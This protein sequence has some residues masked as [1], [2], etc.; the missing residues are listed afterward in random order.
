MGNILL[1]GCCSDILTAWHFPT[2]SLNIPTQFPIRS[3]ILTR[4]TFPAFPDDI[5]PSSLLSS[6]FSLFFLFFFFYS[7]PP[8][9]LCYVCIFALALV[10][11]SHTPRWAEW[12][13]R[14]KTTIATQKPPDGIAH[15]SCVKYLRSIWSAERCINCSMWGNRNRTRLHNVFDNYFFSFLIWAYFFLPSFFCNECLKRLDWQENIDRS[16][17]RGIRIREKLGYLWGNGLLF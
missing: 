8:V 2:P 11:S 7:F 1:E 3:P 16:N 4:W 14:A 9:R 17:C 5:I 10:Y 6:L 12:H 15:F 13:A